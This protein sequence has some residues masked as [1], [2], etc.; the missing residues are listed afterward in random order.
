[1]K[2][3]YTLRLSHQYVLIS[4]SNEVLVSAIHED[5]GHPKPFHALFW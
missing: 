4:G 3:Q 1:M 5:Y 2:I